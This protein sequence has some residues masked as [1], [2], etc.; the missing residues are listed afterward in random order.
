[1]EPPCQKYKTK[2]GHFIVKVAGSLSRSIVLQGQDTARFH[3]IELRV[4]L[5]GKL[6]Q[7]SPASSAARPCTK[8]NLNS[9]KQNPAFVVWGVAISGGEETRSVS[10]ARYVKR[11]FAFLPRWF[12]AE[13][14]ASSIV[15]FSAEMQTLSSA[16][17]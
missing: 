9:E 8:Q 1:M 6:E 16:L 3:V 10:F 15:L 11:Y 14:T 13:S 17:S 7:K 5:V 12:Q 4:D 2:N